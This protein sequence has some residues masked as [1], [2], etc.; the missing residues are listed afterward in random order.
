MFVLGFAGQTSYICVRYI[1]YVSKDM[2]SC[3]KFI[4]GIAPF[5]KCFCKLSFNN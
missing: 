2:Y 1:N 4:E 3:L 5:D